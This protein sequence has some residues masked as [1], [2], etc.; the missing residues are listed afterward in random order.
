MRSLKWLRI[1]VMAMTGLL[2]AAEPVVPEPIVPGP[3]PAGEVDAVTQ[4]RA[5]EALAI[6]AQQPEVAAAMTTD[7]ALLERMAEIEGWQREMGLLLDQ[8]E[9]AAAGERFIK[10][11]EAMRA[12]TPAERAALGRRYTA[13]RDRLQGFARLFAEAG[14]EESTS[15][16]ASPKTVTT[17]P[18]TP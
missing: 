8:Q 4:R 16:E 5:E 6:L 11:G 10:V 15:A 13:A 2:R 14:A 18:K 9:S 3:A 12:L 7:V 17:A 1:L